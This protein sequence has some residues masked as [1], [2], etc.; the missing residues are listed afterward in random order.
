MS[1]LGGVHT[2][3]KLQQARVKA[4]VSQ[5]KA[6]ELLNCDTRTIQ[7]Y[8]AGVTAPTLP[9]LLKLKE[10]YQCEFTDLFPERVPSAKGE[11]GEL[12]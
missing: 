10:Q 12:S 4:G 5:E 11:G 1:R 3:S 9:Q 6:A 2:E 7:R 8:E